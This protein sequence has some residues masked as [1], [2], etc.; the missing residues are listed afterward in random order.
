MINRLWQSKRVR[1]KNNYL[2]TKDFDLT[3]A[4]V[5]DLDIPWILE[6]V[7]LKM[8]WKSLEIKNGKKRHVNSA[9]SL[10][11]RHSRLK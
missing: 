3:V 4:P 11:E 2:I 1:T 10:G 7:N 9:K 5:V 8:E 6:R